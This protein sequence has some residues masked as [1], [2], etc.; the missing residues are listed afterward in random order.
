[1]F[2][3]YTRERDREMFYKYKL[4]YTYTRAPKS[5]CGYVSFFHSSLNNFLSA[6]R[7]ISSSFS[8]ALLIFS[9]STLSLFI[10]K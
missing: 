10:P 1:M 6:L 9:H 7:H 4:A 2:V 8:F 3:S 5:K